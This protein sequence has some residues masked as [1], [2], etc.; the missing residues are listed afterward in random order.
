MCPSKC[1]GS[2]ID[3]RNTAAGVGAGAGRGGRK[4]RKGVVDASDST[5]DRSSIP[6]VHDLDLSRQIDNVVPVVYDLAQVAGWEPCSLHDRTHVPWVGI[7]SARVLEKN[8]RLDQG[9]P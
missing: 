6:A 4:G 8:S 7:G 1:Q 3:R 2:Y 9:R 5:S